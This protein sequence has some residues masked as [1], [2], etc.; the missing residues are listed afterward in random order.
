MVKT[1][2]W[3]VLSPDFAQICLYSAVVTPFKERKQIKVQYLT[4]AVVTLT[5]KIIIYYYLPCTQIPLPVW[6]CL[7]QSSPLPRPTVYR[8]AVGRSLY[9]LQ[10]RLCT[11]V[12]LHSA[13]LRSPDLLI[14]N[15]MIRFSLCLSLRLHCRPV[16]TSLDE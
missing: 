1:S 6:L 8:I 12:H 5:I 3:R 10:C 2:S 16:Y 13:S 9:S 14:T 15:G 11:H 7:A 4:R